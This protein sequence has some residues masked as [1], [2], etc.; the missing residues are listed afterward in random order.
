MADTSA[1]IGDLDATYPPGSESRKTADNI[2]RHIKTVLKTD[3]AEVKGPVTASH[4]ELNY[5]DGVTAPI[6]T[7]LD[8]KAQTASPTFTGT[9]AAPTATPG[10]NSTQIATMEA[11]QAAVAGV[12]ATTGLTY[13]NSDTTSVTISAGQHV[14]CRAGTAVAVTWPTGST[15]GQQ[16]SVGFDN[17]LYTNTINFGAQSIK[18]PNGVTRSGVV[19]WNTLAG[20]RAVW[21]GDYWR[22]LP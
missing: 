13:S 1:H 15:N 2:F 12:N 17:G 20:L 11:V 10:T 19:T 8:A 22:A 7:Q 6:Q 3:F 16:A 18:G 9:P 4:T 21:G 5:T 14:Q